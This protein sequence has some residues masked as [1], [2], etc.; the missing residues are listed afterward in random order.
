M[1]CMH[2]F[3]KKKNTEVIDPILD[4]IN[5]ILTLDWLETDKKLLH[6]AVEHLKYY[7]FLIPKEVEYDV[8]ELLKLT[9][10]EKTEL[11]T[12]KKQISE[13]EIENVELSDQIEE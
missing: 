10:R 4:I 6:K 3:G 9:I 7:K 8:L 12:L 13:K 5:E 2:L 1:Y 11:Q